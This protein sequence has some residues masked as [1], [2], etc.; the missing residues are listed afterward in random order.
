M[1][2]SLRLRV[3]ALVALVNV[4]VFG[5][6]LWFLTGHLTRARQ[7]QLSEFAGDRKSVV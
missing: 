6:G 1:R 7:A 5:A 3:L 4:G 2:I